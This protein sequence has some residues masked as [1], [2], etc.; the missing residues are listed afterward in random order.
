MIPKDQLVVVIR[1]AGERTEQLCKK[2]LLGVV[3][4]SQINIIREVP[5]E[6]ALRKSFFIGTKS[7][8]KWLLVIDADLLVLPDSIRKIVDE[9]NAEPDDVFHIQ[10][11]IFDKFF[12][13]YRKAGP[14]IYR[15]NTLKKAMDLIPVDGEEIRPE[16]STIKKMESEGFRSKSSEVV[17]G[18]HDFEQYYTDIYRK[19]VVHAFKH[20]SEID[21]LIKKWIEKI[22]DNDY[23]IALS[24]SVDAFLSYESVSIDKRLFED[25]SKRLLDRIGLNEKSEIF[26]SDKIMQEL[27]QILDE[28][29]SI[30]DY[31]K[32][33]DDTKLNKS[34]SDFARNLIREKGVFAATRY[35]MGQVIVKLGAVIRGKAH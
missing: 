25:G 2:L 6:S 12:R 1:S 5:F 8:S 4:A 17:F 11:I 22:E 34:R 30:P 18:V 26:D 29:G 35:M 7:D 14:R 3:D 31:M 32:I 19:C 13:D 20:K 16:Y 33:D 24:A 23:R 28:A 21:I 9:A 27:I 10:G 15:V